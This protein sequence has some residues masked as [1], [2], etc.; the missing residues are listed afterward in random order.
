MLSNDSVDL[1][2]LKVGNS[3]SQIFHHYRPC[4]WQVKWRHYNWR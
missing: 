2:F 1:S 4:N 3:R